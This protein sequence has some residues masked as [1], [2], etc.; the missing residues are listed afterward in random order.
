MIK[1]CLYS[2]LLFSIPH[3][4]CAEQKE[5]AG[6]RI[7]AV[8]HYNLAIKVIPEAHQLEVKSEIIL[9]PAREAR[10]SLSLLT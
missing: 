10:N 9:P 4:I 2:I 6:N 5:A 7:N 8:S 1:A 3:A